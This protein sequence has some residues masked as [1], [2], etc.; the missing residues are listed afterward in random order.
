MLLSVPLCFLFL[1]S[2]SHNSQAQLQNG[3]YPLQRISNAPGF[4]L[5]NMEVKKKKANIIKEIRSQIQKHR[6]QAINKN[7]ARYHKAKRN[8]NNI[9]QN[10]HVYEFERCEIAETEI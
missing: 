2:S 1:A 6:N 10:V 9:L 8:P 5:E 4:Q 3:T 7:R